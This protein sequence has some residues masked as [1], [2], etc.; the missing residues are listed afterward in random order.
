MQKEISES[1]AQTAVTCKKAL[2]NKE[3]GLQLI[4]VL[5]PS[6]PFFYALIS[7]LHLQSEALQKVDSCVAI[8]ETHQSLPWLAVIFKSRKPGA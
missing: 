6:S 1:H 8:D 2:R 4:Q 7:I 5:M 3:T